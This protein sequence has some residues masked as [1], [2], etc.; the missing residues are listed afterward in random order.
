MYFITRENICMSDITFHPH[1]ILEGGTGLSNLHSL[2]PGRQGRG[3][4]MRSIPS[5]WNL[6][7]RTTSHHIAKFNHPIQGCSQA[8][9]ASGPLLGGTGGKSPPPL[10]CRAFGSCGISGEGDSGL[11]P[12]L[13]VVFVSQLVTDISLCRCPD[14]IGVRAPCFYLR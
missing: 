8:F 6:D 13:L 4:S 3:L 5:P 1:N 10:N 14:L 12:L 11:P 2:N 7:S 9:P